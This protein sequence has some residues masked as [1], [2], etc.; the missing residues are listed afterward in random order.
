V[1]L[2]IIASTAE[3]TPA[4]AACADWNPLAP[5]PTAP[6]PFTADDLIEL[7]G[8]GRPDA[9]PTG[10]SSPLAISP[11]ERYA[12][13]VLQRADTAENRYCQ[14][15]VLIDLEGRQAPR[16]LDRGGEFIM[17]R[18]VLRGLATPNGYP[19]QIIPAW[20]PDGRTIAY[21]RRDNGSTQLWRVTVATGVAQQLT[22]ENVDVVSWAWLAE[23]ARIGFGI[24]PARLR[25]E[26]AIDAEGR[27]GWVYDERVTPNVGLRPQPS[28]PL[29]TVFKIVDLGSGAVEPASDTEATWLANAVGPGDR[30]KASAGLAQAWTEANA[31][32]P[33][34]S[35]RLHVVGHDGHPEACTAAACTG[36]FE[37][38]WWADAGKTLLFLKREGWND[39]YTALYTWS[40]GRSPPERLLRTDDLIERCLP[41]RARLLCI[42][43]TAIRPSHLVAVDPTSGAI[44]TVFDPNPGFGNREFG[45]VKRLTWRNDLGLE[46]YGDLVLPSGYS[47]GTRLPTIVVLYRSRGFLRG[48]TGTEYPIHLFARR[49]FAVLSIE[50]PALYAARYPDLK[51]PDAIYAVNARDWSDRR[52]MH[53]AIATGVKLLVSRGIADPRRLGITGLSDGATSVRYAL[54]NSK[55]F[56]AASLSS[57]CVD[58]SSPVLAGPAWAQFTSKVGF[59]PAV[60]VDKT[61]WKPV[62]LVLNAERITTPLLMQLADSESLYALPSI[63]ALRQHHQPTEVRIFPGEFHMKWQPVHRAAIYET[64]LDWFDFW[65]NG[66]VDPAPD[67]AEQYRRWQRLRA[68]RAQPDAASAVA[69]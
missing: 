19:Q 61:F 25:I 13:F 8:I 1:L 49:G 62:S 45:N 18:V 59:P 44:E 24:Q 10:G 23:G 48:G 47:R 22:R 21:L 38:L 40:P 55:L 67:K 7:T 15:L 69:P 35:R 26:S 41:V 4:L 33:L 68:K 17:T 34:S 20:S 5:P 65:L 39:R 60:P 57:C 51:T 37:D 54:I 9:E 31:P 28:A 2:L 42:R 29:P 46:V 56:G 6:R 64:N 63:T 36:R 66:K 14:A 11:D 27:T 30:Q 32:S 12:A 53:S 52:N 16:M 3:A 50:R 58:E 43:E